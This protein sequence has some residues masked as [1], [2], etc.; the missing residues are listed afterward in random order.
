MSI[1]HSL[2]PYV[3]VSDVLTYATILFARF[4]SLFVFLLTWYSFEEFGAKELKPEGGG[5]ITFWYALYI[6]VTVVLMLFILKDF[7]LDI[8]D[9]QKLQMI[10]KVPI[11]T[12]VLH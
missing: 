8:K 5:P 9:L 2:C 4:Y 1:L 6:I 7:V 11:R 12:S 10:K 3:L